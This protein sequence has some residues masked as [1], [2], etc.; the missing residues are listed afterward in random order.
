MAQISRPFQIALGAIV[1]LA[2]VWLFALHGHSSSSGEP[3]SSATPS[4]S[5]SASSPASSASSSSP[6]ASSAASGEAQA[7]AAAAPTHVYHGAAPGVE[8]LTK[9]IAKAHETV[10][11]SQTSAKQ[12]EHE[13]ATATPRAGASTTYP[14]GKPSSSS[15]SSSAAATRTSSSTTVSKS[16]VKST[17]SKTSGSG[18]AT[19]TTTSL[20][21]QGLVEGQLH[22]G[23]VV[24]VLFWNPLGSDDVAVFRQSL[25]VAHHERGHVAVLPAE[26][27]EVASF[28]SITRGVQVYGTP[29]LLVVGKKGQTQVITG[30]TDAYAIEQAITEITH[31]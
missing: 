8:G 15:S 25:L 27:D 7:N 20:A 9:A 11:N 19:A 29:T 17:S 12:V 13:S 26:A 31:A 10:A 24:L 5:Q 1:L 18:A 23:R 16:A 22:A 4:S 21:N 2:G 14:E 30:L 3:S 6:A 28:G